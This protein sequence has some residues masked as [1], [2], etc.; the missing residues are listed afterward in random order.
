MSYTAT[1]DEMPSMNFRN[2]LCWR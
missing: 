1:S 2:C